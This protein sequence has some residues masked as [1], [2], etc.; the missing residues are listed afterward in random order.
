MFTS[1]IDQTI[2]MLR[3]GI[4]AALIAGVAIPVAATKRDLAKG[5]KGGGET[6]GKSADSITST[7][8]AG[9]YQYGRY[10]RYGTDLFWHRFWTFG[11][12]N[13]FT[14]QFERVD[15]YTP[16]LYENQGAILAAAQA[17]LREALG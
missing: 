4:D 14:R 5:F 1:N 15:L 2:A 6:S 12:M 7:P 9:D 17:A 8:V 13:A 3:T 10:I 11:G 16:N